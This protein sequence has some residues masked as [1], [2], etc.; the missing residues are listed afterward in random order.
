M[1]LT[2]ILHR[3]RVEYREA[4]QHHHARVGWIQ[5]KDC[6]F[7][8]S[9]NYHLGYNLQAGFFSCWRCGGHHVIS[10]LIR[11]G[12]SY[13]EAKAF[14]QSGD[15][16]PIQERPRAG[17][18]EPAGRGPLLPCHR[19]YLRCRGFDA[20]DIE[21]IWGLEG[22]GLASRLPW[23]LYIPVIYR[24]EKVSWTTRAIGEV[25]QRY[26]SASAQEE[27]ITIKHLVYGIDFCQHSIIIVEGPADAWRIGP[28]AGALFGTAFTSSQVRKL[29]RIPHRVICFDSSL[30]AQRQA[31]SLAAQ[32]GAFPGETI[33]VELDAE[34]PGSASLKEVRQIR[35]MA[36]LA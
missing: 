1:N 36:K 29:G 7:C 16:Q 5:L 9:S 24:G 34:D 33:V 23:R 26:I 10:V 27:S 4:G 28:G 19:R 18:K 20:A 3:L 30:N 31:R 13:E 2:D 35:A 17:L 12:L 14:H 6:P 22:I 25:S 32:L 11:L 8:H 21:R 15:F